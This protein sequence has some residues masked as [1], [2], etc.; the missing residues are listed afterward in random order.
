MIIIKLRISLNLWVGNTIC[1]MLGAG[2]KVV[3]IL[4]L[5]CMLYIYTKISYIINKILTC[6]INSLKCYKMLYMLLL[7]LQLRYIRIFKN[8]TV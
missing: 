8:I 4:F 7:I 2:L 3:N 1:E 6:I 5:C